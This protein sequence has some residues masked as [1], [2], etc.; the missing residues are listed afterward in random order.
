MHLV[1]WISLLLLLA[2]VGSVLPISASSPPAS[3]PPP[4]L[5]LAAANVDLLSAPVLLDEATPSALKHPKLDSALVRLAQ[6]AEESPE[7]A[8]GLAAAQL[9]RV[10]EGRVQTQV[11]TSADRLKRAVQAITEAGGVVTK[12]GYQDTLIQAWLPVDA[13]E[14]V[15]ASPDVLSIRRPMEFATLGEVNPSA[16]TSEGLWAMNAHVWH[17]AGYRGAGVKIGII[18]GGFLGYSALRGTELPAAITVKTFVD[19]ETD[20]KV[21]GSS[22]HGT[23]CA[24]IIHDI[25]PDA[26]LYLAKINTDI[27]LE[28][29]A[30]WLL[31]QG[32]DIVSVSLGWFHEAGDGT[33]YLS[34]IIAGVR[35]AGVLW[36][37]AA[38]N[39]RESHWR[40]LFT[41]TDG[42]GF[43]DF[44][45]DGAP[46]PVNFF[47]PGDGRVYLIPAGTYLRVIARWSDWENVDQDLDLHM[48]RL[49]PSTNNWDFIASS[50][51]AQSGQ[52]GQK[53]LEVVETM[54]TGGST[55]YGVVIQRY[56]T[57]RDVNIDLFIANG[58]WP[59]HDTV[60]DHSLTL[61][62]DS[63]YAL[64]VAAL[65]V[66][67]PYLQESYSS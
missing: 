67:A 39:E 34:S 24:E 16:L 43:Q 20:D 61:P 64:T 46:Y 40:G 11:T 31:A 50:M 1:R 14:R 37:N 2:L 15:A 48:V 3:P 54:T 62:G 45:L 4:A 63:P 18:D 49:N 6:V 23:A 22:P 9:L 7:R 12:V 44:N 25:A 27:D 38:G 59:F 17:A 29:A 57:V 10:S 32:V 30:N 28:Q 53:P 21:D 51:A 55:A 13:L 36:V 56:G 60:H 8:V 65:D 41:D 66:D 33:G 42:N 5:E 35:S 26:T 47:G 58:S 19:G 52:Y